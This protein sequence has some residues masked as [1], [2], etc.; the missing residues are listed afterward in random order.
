MSNQMTYRFSSD[1]RR[2]SLL[3]YGAMRM[4]TVDGGHANSWAP[5]GYSRTNIDQELLERQIRMLL[6]GGVNYFD[7]SPAYCRGESESRLGRAL[8]KSGWKREDYLVATKLSNFAPS[9]FSL[10]ACKKMFETSLRNL[11][12]D[13]IDNY[14]LHSIGNDGFSTFSRR[15]LENGALDWCVRLREEKRIRN[16]G[17]SFHGDPKAF[18]WCMEHHGEYRWDFC[19]IQMNYV[20]WR[21]AQE[22]NR[23]NLNA[24]Y[25]YSTLTEKRIP[26]VIMEPLLG[27]RLARYNAALARNLKP[28]APNDSLARWAF[29]FS[30]S[31]PNVMTILSG[32][33]RTSDIEDNLA[34]FSPLR[35]CT[36]SEFAALQKAAD[37][38]MKSDPIPCTACQ[39]CMPCPFGLDIPSV[40]RFRNEFLVSGEEK[41][42]EEIQAAY[43]KAVPDPMRR[44]ERCVG[45]GVC[46]PH[47]PQ[48]IR[49]P[50]EMALIDSQMNDLE[51][52][53]FRAE[54]RARNEE[55]DKWL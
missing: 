45:C 11:Q 29:R 5:N 24:E 40:F 33:T 30:G 10:D 18:E 3:G 7:T 25:L 31:M 34:T 6:E 46:T 44:A 26:V 23:R 49:I 28:L 12:T 20:D 16:L 36:E 21:H 19:Q 43:E 53:R 14:L 41:T 38:Y 50:Q 22:I 55:A 15:Y 42:R 35:P 17:F 37:E 32:M 8:A 54:L 9:Q 39:Y 13:Y 52:L 2:V 47:C 1:G 27:G 4:A 48:Q 51:K